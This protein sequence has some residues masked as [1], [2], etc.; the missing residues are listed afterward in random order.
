MY[1]DSPRWDRLIG[2]DWP[3]ASWCK[4]LPRGVKG[5]A[6][7]HAPHGALG[8]PGGLAFQLH[9]DPFWLP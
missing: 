9:I 1:P 5:L 8:T 6:A 2:T 7:A 4:R 3:S